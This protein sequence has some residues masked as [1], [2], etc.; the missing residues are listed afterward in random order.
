MRMVRAENRFV[1]RLAPLIE[2]LSLGVLA[3]YA[4]MNGAAE[5]NFSQNEI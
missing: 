2:R 4:V 3:L 1:Y 5:L